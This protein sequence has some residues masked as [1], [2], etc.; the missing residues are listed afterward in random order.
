[1]NIER[2][3]ATHTPAWQQLDELLTRA[4][5]TEVTREELQ[6]LVGLY[7]STCSDLN[8]ARSYTANPEVLGYLN[9]LTGRAYRFIY[10]A[11]H[12]VPVRR[13]FA[14]LIT[15]EIPSA[16]RRER[17]V[18]AIAAAAMVLGA[19]F[20]AL[21]VIVDPANGPR[22]IPGMFFT[23]SPRER[24]EKIESGKERIDNRCAE[25]AIRNSD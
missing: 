6:E 12:D 24:V 14:A 16:F 8:R 1:M 5:E 11:A 18:I 22:L 17:L 10:Q 19:L 3:I 20:G 4:E 21:A 13:A 15:S 23:E 25:L 9:Q 7:R 2:F